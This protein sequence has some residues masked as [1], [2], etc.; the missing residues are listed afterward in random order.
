MPRRTAFEPRFVEFVPE[1][2]EEGVLYISIEYATV[3]HKCYC[4]CGNQVVTPLAPVFWELTFDGEAVSLFPS[5]GS[6]GFPCRSHYWIVRNRVVESWP[7]SDDE[8]AYARGLDAR[9][10]REYFGRRWEREVKRDAAGADDE[11]PE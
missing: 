10:R 6:W 3:V 8:I 2:V 5:V 4:G 7:W 1:L 11:A 9:G